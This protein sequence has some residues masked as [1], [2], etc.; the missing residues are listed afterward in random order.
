MRQ[1]LNNLIGNACKFTKKGTITVSARR[2]PDAF[3][4]R[5]GITLSIRDTGVGMTPEQQSKL[6]QP[7]AKLSEKQGNKDGTGL[8]LVITRGFCERMG[9]CIEFDSEIGKGTAFHVRMPPS[10]K[11]ESPVSE[12]GLMKPLPP[13]KPVAPQPPVTSPRDAVESPTEAGKEHVVL[14]ID[15]DPNVQEMM[16]RFLEAR[17]FVVHS[18]SSGE[19]GLRLAKQLK[20]A[21]ITL[22][23]LMPNM[24]GWE[25]LAAL[26]TNDVTSRIPVIMVTMVDDRS[27][28]YALGVSDFL[29]KPVDW[30]Q[31]EVALRK[32]DGV[33]SDAEVLVVDDDADHR[34]LVRRQL[35]KGGYRVV[36]AGNGRDGLEPARGVPAAVDPAGPD[37]ADHGWIRIRRGGPSRSESLDDSD[38]RRHGQGRRAG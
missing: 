21:V 17:G 27:K 5:D 12:S 26:K 23:A 19:E 3:D 11:A 14:V 28:G 2:E 13:R 22:D 10:S 30:D 20:P 36:E 9:G 25:T 16:R 35:E 31:L 4:G 38:H 29:V 34:S 33:A 32:Y 37:D 7:F 6:F 15:D 8:G 18:A 1:I 24:D